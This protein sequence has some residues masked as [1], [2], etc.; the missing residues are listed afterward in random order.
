MLKTETSFKGSI[1]RK[2]LRACLDQDYLAKV[3]GI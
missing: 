2:F 1:N 3:L